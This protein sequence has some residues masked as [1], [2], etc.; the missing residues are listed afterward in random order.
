[1]RLT[2]LR[3]GAD[4]GVGPYGMGRYGEGM[5]TMAAALLERVPNTCSDSLVCDD[6][7]VA[8]DAPGM[9]PAAADAGTVGFA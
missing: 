5:A 8:T 9:L 7:L 3:A 1:M 4:Y 6:L 2:P